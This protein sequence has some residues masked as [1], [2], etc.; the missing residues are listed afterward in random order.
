[1]NWHLPGRIRRHMDFFLMNY[2]GAKWLK[3]ESL[4]LDSR[5]E[6]SEAGRA[7]DVG[8]LLDLLTIINVRYPSLPI[9]ITENGIAD[10]SDG[11][12]SAYMI[13][14]LA[15]V[16]NA[17]ARKIPVQG[18]FVWTLTDNLEWSDG[19]CPKFG[20]VSVDRKTMI[21]TPR[22]SYNLYQQIIGSK[23]ITEAQR[24]KAP[25]LFS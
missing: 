17:I 21:R 23:E 19:Y 24:S 1:M 13:Q 8:G 4:S 2:Y 25:S 14:H 12:R 7:I 3:G 6:Y 5:E 9:L 22:P 16:Q 11:I 10:A 20:L 18:Y 15:A